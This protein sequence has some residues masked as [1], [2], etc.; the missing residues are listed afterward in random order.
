MSSLFAIKTWLISPTG[1]HDAP[2]KWRCDNINMLTQQNVWQQH[3]T[4]LA[5]STYTLTGGGAARKGQQRAG[6]ELKSHQLIKPRGAGEK[7]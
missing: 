2:F 5:H 3:P 4:W 6:N 1:Y 7:C